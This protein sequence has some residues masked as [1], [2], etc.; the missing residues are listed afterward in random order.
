LA[1]LVLKSK[2]DVED[3]VVGCTFY[4]T[5][6]GGRPELGRQLLQDDLVKMGEI[7]VSDPASIRDDA[8][9]CT[10]YLMGS[11]APKTKETLA[12][13]AS[14]GASRPIGMADR[15][16][17]L[18]VLELESYAGVEIEAIVPIE[19]GAA[20]TPAP[21]DVALSLGKRVVN[22]DYAGRAIPEIDQITAYLAEKPAHP[23]AYV[24]E[25]GN[26]SIIKTAVNYYF[27]EALG[28]MLSIAAFGRVGGAGFLMRA[29]EMKEILIANTLSECLIVGQ[30]IREAVTRKQDPADTVAEAIK[31]WVLFRGKVSKKEW[32]DR[33]GYMWGINTIEG[34]DQF[35]GHTFKIFFKNENHVTWLDD[36]PY[37]TSPDIIEVIRRDSGMPITNTDIKEGDHVSVLGLRGRDPF[38]A[39]KGLSVLGPQHFGYDI[40]YLP[41]ES[42]M[43]KGGR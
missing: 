9:V 33:D 12:K 28:K 30:T 16:L 14:A 34:Q 29:K 1:D 42:I 5:G 6:G 17:T 11:I 39:A 25:W 32:E 7:R 22:G 3:F 23:T 41:I 13:M 19:L 2:D 21:I 37:V 10:P 43:K 8:W 38:K 15:M 20:N 31:G 24:D 26:V 36:R 27:A 18:A 40:P 4:G 35:K